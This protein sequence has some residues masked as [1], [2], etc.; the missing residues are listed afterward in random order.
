MGHE[1]VA[2][3]MTDGAVRYTTTRRPEEVELQ[4]VSR[5]ENIQITG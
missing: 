2:V 5:L 4:G 1:V 3:S